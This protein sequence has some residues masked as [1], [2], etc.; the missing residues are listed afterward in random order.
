MV[1][2]SIISFVNVSI[3]WLNLQNDALVLCIDLF[4]QDVIGLM[5]CAHSFVIPVHQEWFIVDISTPVRY[6]QT[7]VAAGMKF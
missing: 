5:V 4:V 1:T 3:I 7:H 2:I 6:Q